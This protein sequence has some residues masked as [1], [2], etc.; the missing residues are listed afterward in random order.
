M[1][2]LLSFIGENDCYPFERKGAILSILAKRHFDKVYLLYNKEKYLKPASDINRYCE[3]YFPQISVAYKEAPAVNPTDYNTVYPAMYKAVVEITKENKNAEY[4]I[5]LTSGTPTMH[6]CWIFLQ[7]GGVIKAN[8]IQVSRERIISEVDFN[9]DDFP[10][11]QKVN[12]I[13][14]EISRLA[15]E[16]VQLKNRLQLQHDNIIGECPAILKVKEQIQIFSEAPIPIFITGETGTGKELVAEAIHYNSQRKEYQFIPINCGAIPEHL[17][18]SELFGHKKGAFTGAIADKPGKFEL[19]DKGTIFLDEVA[20]LPPDMQVKLLRVLQEGTFIPVGETRE[21]HADVRVISA[22]NQDIKQH[23]KDGKFREDLF[24]R[25]VHTEIKLPP[26]RQRGDDVI[27]IANHLLQ[28][29]NFKY[30]TK[31]IITESAVKKIINYHYPGNIRQLKNSLEA[32]YFQ[33]ENSILPEH[34]NFIDIDH[35][36]TRIEIPDSGIDLEN[37]IIPQYYQ[38]AL[39]KTNG[40]A[41]Q[42]ARLLNLAPHTF[43]ARLRKLN[44]K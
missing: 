14:T 22:T 25:L 34:L 28:Q 43:R 18:E 20:E 26:L 33:A 39:E 21:F 6:A 19:A 24:Y 29:M 11:I 2:I 32:A 36:T 13:K 17:F 15:R 8:L 3:Q 30:N 7:Q 41:E 42:A 10:Q 4:T 35:I 27:L 5:S 37:D 44:G 16:N 38:A 1:Q 40:N 23:V 9:L 31:K 12:E